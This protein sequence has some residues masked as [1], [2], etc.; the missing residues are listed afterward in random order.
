MRSF[1]LEPDLAVA[2]KTCCIAHFERVEIVQSVECPSENNCF[3]PKQKV[4]QHKDYAHW[5]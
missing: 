2:S 1:D 4:L 3:H 5:C